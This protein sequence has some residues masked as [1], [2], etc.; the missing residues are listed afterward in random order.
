MR[1]SIVFKL[2]LAIA[3]VFCLFTSVITIAQTLLLE[4][5]YV[6]KKVD[7]IEKDLNKFVASYE[8]QSWDQE[9][10]NKSIIDFYERNNAD[11]TV[12]DLNAKGFIKYEKAFEMVVRTSANEEI[13][14]PLTNILYN[15]EQSKIE[16]LNLKEGTNV[17]VTGA[18]SDS[19]LTP[20]SIKTKDEEWI[21]KV[22]R[23]LPNLVVLQGEIIK[24][25]MPNSG[26]MTLSSKWDM[27]FRG[28]LDWGKSLENKEFEIGREGDVYN[29]TDSKTG[30]KNK[31]FVKP[32]VHE[33]T[34][35]EIAFA[36]TSLQPVDEAVGV[37]KSF[38]WY[39]FFLSLLLIV[40]ISFYF[41]K[42]ITNPLIKM[43]RVTRKMASLDFSEK[44]KTNSNDEIGSLSTS[45]NTL[46][47]NLKRTIDELQ[48][49]NKQLQKDIEKERKLENTRKEFISGVSHELKTPLSVIKS[50][51]EGVKD[52]I[53]KER[54]EYYTEVIL[55]E[56][57]KMDTLIV[58]MLE[59]AKL[60][61]GT[62]H[63]HTETFSVVGLL[64]DVYH[65][66]L[67]VLQDKNMDVE[68]I[69]DD[70]YDVV[71]DRRRIEQVMTNFITNA[72]RY[73]NE[74]SD[75][76]IRLVQQETAVKIEIE[77]EGPTIPEEVMEKLWERF[78]RVD[79]SR[80]RHKGGTGLGL[81]IVRNILELHDAPFGVENKE[82]GVRFYFYLPVYQEKEEK[83]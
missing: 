51:T 58:D 32:I 78:Y 45:I 2:F 8:G 23:N 56:I 59:L 61:S 55:E 67:F 30:I 63:V 47:D 38:Y 50:Y 13:S 83:E 5:F 1:T 70:D 17:I 40:F 53:S 76:I 4:K 36:M 24:V 54:T 25:T 49:A 57:E 82:N 29:Y 52:N 65:K 6:M 60:E 37:A 22:N 34:V 79:D 21:G 28:I 74:D 14:V 64:D 10:L 12:L 46:S 15:G 43:N 35:T 48:I 31:I 68:F 7:S 26:N 18:L 69:A 72:V 33:N 9:T 42:I 73:G 27:F 71:A 20:F 80:N 3:L 77:N 19:S 75:I 11:L 39:A 16:A 81:S 41:S 66:L 62:Y 44:I